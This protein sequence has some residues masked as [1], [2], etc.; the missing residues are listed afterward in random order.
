V[1][2]SFPNS[3]HIS[4]EKNQKDFLFTAIL[5]VL[6]LKT[7]TRFHSSTWETN[8]FKG[9]VVYAKYNRDSY[10]SELGLSCSYFS[11]LFS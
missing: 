5:V 6:H 11:F 9:L 7:L 8:G 3:V 1:C 2:I 4:F 10:D